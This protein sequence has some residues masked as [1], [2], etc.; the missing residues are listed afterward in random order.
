MKSSTIPRRIA[1]RDF[2]RN[3]AAGNFQISPDGEFISYLKPYQN[4]MNIF[5]RPRDGGGE[6]RVSSATSRDITAYMWKNDRLLYMR[7]S[8]GDEN[9]RLYS[10]DRQGNNY[11]DLTP[12]E[13]VRVK[14][15]DEL[16]DI[17]DE[18]LIS[19]N[20]RRKDVF[21]VYRLNIETGDLQMVAENPGNITSWITDHEGRLRLAFA[22]DGVD[23]AIL[24]RDSEQDEFRC[25]MRNNF[26]TSVF[27]LFFTFDNANFYAISNQNRDKK[28]IVLF[29]I[30]QGRERELLFEHPDVDV[31]GLSYS[32][33][34]KRLWV[35]SF[36]TWKRQLHFFDQEIKEVYDSL[37]RRFENKEVS[38]VDTDKTERRLIVRSYSDRSLGSYY[39]YDRADDSLELLCEVSPWL[40]EEELCPMKP[41]EFTARDGL[42]IHGYLTLPLGRPGRNLPTVLHV[43]GGPWARDSWGY[44]AQTQFLANRGYAVLQ[45]NFRGS[46][47]YGR[48][49]WKASFR[50]WGAAM[51]DD[52]SDGV[53]W[54]IDQGIADPDRVAIYGGSYGGYATLAGLCFTPDLYTCG[55]DFVGVS[56]LLTFMNSIPPYWKPLQTKMYE[57]IGHPERD[58]DMLTQRSPVFNVDKIKA[59][60]LVAQ[61]AKDPRVNIEESNQI[62]NAL[63][64]RGIDVP[65][66]V[67]DNEGHGF[68]NEENRLEFY[69]AMEQFLAKHLE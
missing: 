17:N 60:L 18:V 56:N 41:I 3:P 8:A 62:V 43:H 44:R 40:N 31:S 37:F 9:Y 29:D 38:I 13:N 1:L 15:V 55:I 48:E 11:R 35:A 67:K 10:V 50:Q 20:H 57:I 23:E 26:K 12:F 25:L 16:P 5:V 22:A 58:R 4:R 54:L 66:I 47:G 51:Q 30:A 65:Y 27:P 63:R 39:L 32:H 69:E 46:T 24:Y 53:H 49:F 21:D 68:H 42:Q 45:I 59:P 52:L 33:Y 2:F 6:R 28:A 7:D 61:G 14:L 34:H 36:T 64:E 19:M